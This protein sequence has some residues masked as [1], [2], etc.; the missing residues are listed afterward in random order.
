MAAWKCFESRVPHQVR[1]LGVSNV[2]LAT[3]SV[4]YEAAT[5][6]PALVQNRFHGMT[7]YDGPV[8]QFCH[9][10]GIIYQSFWT[11]T[12]N[13]RLLESE[14]IKL[15]SV[16]IRTESEQSLY[17]CVMG[18]GNI[19]VLDGTTKFEN[20]KDDIKGLRTWEKWI[21]KEGSQEKWKLIM[22]KFES[23]IESGEDWND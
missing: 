7:K 11:L 5:I 23:L 2:D 22:K 1:S 16:E 3:L 12:A 10:H 6:K 14:F 9:E 20:M 8:R 17:L 13:P 15:V 19:S 21:E 4:L 18:L